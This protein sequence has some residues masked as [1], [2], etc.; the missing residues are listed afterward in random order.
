MMALLLGGIRLHGLEFTGNPNAVVS[1]NHESRAQRQSFDSDSNYC[2]APPQTFAFEPAPAVFS[3]VVAAQDVFLAAH[4]DGWHSNRP[5][6][7]SNIFHN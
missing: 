4:P 2:V 1:S 6:P 7:P 3:R 5:P